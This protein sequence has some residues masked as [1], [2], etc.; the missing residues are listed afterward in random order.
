MTLSLFEKDE[1]LGF[2]K[3]KIKLTIEIETGTEVCKTNH[4][5]K[6]FTLFFYPL[7]LNY[8]TNILCVFKYIF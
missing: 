7:R 5:E 2:P 8:F 6:Y 3:K 1:V 4:T